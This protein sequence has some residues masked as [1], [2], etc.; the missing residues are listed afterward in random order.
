MKARVLAAAITLAACGTA[1]ADEWTFSVTPYL[2]ATDVGI[3]VDLRDRELVDTTIAFDDL[4]KDLESATLVRAEAM[5]G[6]HGISLDLFDVV[7]ADDSGRV[8]LPDGSGSELALDAEVGMTIFDLTG[9]YDPGADG[10]GLSFLYGT[11]IINQREDIGIQ[12][13]SDGEPGGSAAYDADDTFVDGLVG[14][15]YARELPGRWSYQFAADVSTGGTELTW[16]AGPSIGYAFGDTEQYRL[17]AGYRKLSVD[18]DTRPE[19]DMD[20]TLSGFLVGFRFSF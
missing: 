10:Q 4:L 9:V 14:I 5:R 3:D 8:A 2:W 17:T 18:F 16:S 1:H 7:V 6:E 12:L 13:L 19:V 15:R 11:R 20:M